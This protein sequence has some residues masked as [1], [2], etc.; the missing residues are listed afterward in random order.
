MSG[1]LVKLA[2]PER[3][4]GVRPRLRVPDGTVVDDAGAVLPTTSSDHGVAF[5]AVG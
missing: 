5:Q 3:I 1:L 2:G 4:P